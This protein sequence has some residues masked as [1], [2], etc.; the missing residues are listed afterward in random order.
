M[1]GTLEFRDLLTLIDERSTAFRA[2]IAH[3]PDLEA[4]VP[5]CP[6]WTLLELV[7]HLADGRRAWA[8]TIAAGPTATAETT[9]E[10]TEVLDGT[11]VAS[12]DRAALTAWLA[13]STEDLLEQLRAAGP[14]RG[15]WTWWG[16]SQSPQ[17][18]GAVA[19]HQLQ[20]VAV[21]TYDAQLTV[22]TPKPLPGEVAV[23]GV[24]EFLTTCCATTSP[25]PH[26]PAIV[27]YHAS[28]GRSWRVWLSADGAR[29]ARL[30]APGATPDASARGTASDLVLMLYGRVPVD[31]LALEGDPRIFD[32]LFEWDP[33]A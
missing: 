9:P 32:Q 7:K 26:E 18:C 16:S 3:A 4:Q 12:A 28:E 13:A 8:A 31:S 1:K 2:V 33:G 10:P 14:D 23:D 5:S 20:Q 19:R 22:G 21:H 6:E 15:C 29:S 30:D 27:D 25:W 17:T 11:P 24:E